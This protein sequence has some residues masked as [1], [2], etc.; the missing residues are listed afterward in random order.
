MELKT[1]SLLTNISEDTDE[2]RE[3]S[4]DELLQKVL[5]ENGGTLMEEDWAQYVY[6]IIF[7]IDYQWIIRCL[8]KLVILLKR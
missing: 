2:Q 6:Y 4:R 8:K 5:E 3:S 7:V 1:P